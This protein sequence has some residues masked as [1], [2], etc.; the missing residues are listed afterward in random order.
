MGY[1]SNRQRIWVI[2]LMSGATSALDF[3]FLVSFLVVSYLR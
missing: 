3:F 2:L 1:T